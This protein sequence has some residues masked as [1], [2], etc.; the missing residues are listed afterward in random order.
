MN[1]ITGSILEV[2]EL[3]LLSWRSLARLFSKPVYFREAV[4][5]MDIVG[6]GSLPIICLSALS[7]GAVLAL[8]TADTLESFGAAGYTGRLVATSLITE[9]G[10]VLT[11]III[12]GRIG[13]GIA[14]ELGSMVVSEQVDAMRA[15]GTDPIR[16][17]VVPR[18]LALI[19]MTPALVIISVLVGVLGGWII[20]KTQ[21][22]I[23]TSTYFSSARE[24]LNYNDLIGGLLKA[25]T[26]GFIVAIIGCRS[27][28]RTYG[29]T[30][31]VGRSTTQ[32]VVA[33]IVT[34]LVADFFLQKL[35]ITFSRARIFD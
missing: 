30:V 23:A 27:G 2:Q 17:L 26:F 35:I 31:G 5:Q 3:A 28:L 1:F 32:S 21:M 24:A 12:A 33:S 10:P 8:N 9:L 6:V 11:S 34:I 25:V 18:I 13:A 19:T 22:G 15:L 4:H 29:G 16:K 20:A 14:A 7:I